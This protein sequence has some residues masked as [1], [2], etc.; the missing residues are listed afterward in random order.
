MVIFRVAKRKQK[1]IEISWPV[2]SNRVPL[3]AVRPAAV[4][5]S[6][7]S[8]S[9]DSCSAQRTPRRLS[10]SRF[11]IGSGSRPNRDSQCSDTSC[12]SVGVEMLSPGK[13]PS[14]EELEKAGNVSIFDAEGNSR[15][16]KSLYSGSQ[17]IGE[18]QLVIFVRHFFCGV[19]DQ[20]PKYLASLRHECLSPS[21]LVKHTSKHYRVA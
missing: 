12:S 8:S 11:S 9:S 16:F 14:D 5:P 13:L 18:Q 1:K 21:R 20:L 4:L 10:K 17:A 7:Y 3:E 19:S 2:E 15:P 6:L